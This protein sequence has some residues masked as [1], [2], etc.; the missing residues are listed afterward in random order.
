[1]MGGRP[2]KLHS[3]S[4]ILAECFPWQKAQGIRFY[5]NIF[6][7]AKKVFPVIL[8]NVWPCVCVHVCVS[9]TPEMT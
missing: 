3:A 4:S 1:M 8:I 5:S 9:V 2:R 6:N 7:K